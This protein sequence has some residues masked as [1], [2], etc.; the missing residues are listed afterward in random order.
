MTAESNRRIAIV[1]KQKCDPIRCSKECIKYDPINRSGGEGFHLGKDGKAQIAE[2]LTTEAHQICAKKCPFDAIKIIRLPTEASGNP[3]H[4]FGLNGFRLYNL[5]IPVFGKVVGILGRNGIGKSTAVKI[6]SGLLMP[7]LGDIAKK[8]EDCKIQDII[9]F[10]K[11]T[12]AQQYFE[13]MRDGKITV[14]LKPQGINLIAQQH[15]GKVSDLLG[16]INADNEKVKNVIEK[17]QLTQVADHSLDTLSGGEIQRVAIAATLLKTANVYIFDE[18]SSFLDIKQRLNVSKIIRDLANNT[19]GGEN[20][21]VVVIEHDLIILDYMADLIHL[22]YGSQAA[23]GIIS[24]GKSAKN[25]INIYLDGYLRE[26]N[27]RFRDHAIKFYTHEYRD[28]QHVY[29]LTKWESF[30]KKQGTFT[31]TAN[32]GSIKRNTVV[33]VL[34]ENGIG[35]ST[36]A[37]ILSGVEKPDSGS[38][39]KNVSLAY[40][41]QHI[42]TTDEMLVSEYLAHAMEQFKSQ[43]IEPLK[44]EK[45]L[46]QRLCDLSG[47]QL[48]CVKVA[49]CLSQD[50]E[51]YVMDEPSAYLDTEQRLLISKIIKDWMITFGKSAIIIDHDL[52]FID[53]ISDQLLVFD[54]VPAISGSARGP[55]SLQDGMNHF[56]KDIGITFRRDEES[57]RPR[58]N[59]TDSQMD[60]QQKS[61]NK[62]YYA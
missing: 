46:T 38:V 9:Q 28:E 17:L 31:L 39:D 19:N 1:D 6:L 35:K 45:L 62:W 49:H 3:V 8:P 12:L 2:E 18:P 22:S 41:P 43:L 21:A 26:E 52:L 11:G 50:V 58:A 20:V 4:Q 7:N 54:G 30:T 14:A 36:F 55:F 16:K 33:G 48:Q 44:I 47:G 24:Q 37:K 51:L 25:G 60:Q 23:Y 27:I 59:K 56:L 13:R 40:K 53:Y 34:G 32:P 15:K 61:T 42:D 10:F 5:P 57:S 29:N